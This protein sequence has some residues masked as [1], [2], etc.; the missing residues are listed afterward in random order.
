MAALLAVKN[1]SCLRP[2]GDSIFLN[3]NFDVN[4]DDIIVIQAGS[5]TG[6]VVSRLP[7]SHR[8]RCPRWQKDNL[9]EVYSPP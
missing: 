4:E 7:D 5:G 9:I 8:H 6:S 3:V 1:L 2:E